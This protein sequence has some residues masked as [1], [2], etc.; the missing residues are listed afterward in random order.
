MPIPKTSK[1][2]TRPGPSCHIKFSSTIPYV[3]L[4][5]ESNSDEPEAEQSFPVYVTAYLISVNLT[6]KELSPGQLLRDTGCA[7]GLGGGSDTTPSTYQHLQTKQ[8]VPSYRHMY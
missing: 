1:S 3:S 5:F 4:P 2:H 6:S 7:H 8:Y